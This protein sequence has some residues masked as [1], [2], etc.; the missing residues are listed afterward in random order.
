M[1]V[2]V[3]G[4]D[5][6]RQLAGLL[7]RF[8]ESEQPDG[9]AFATDL[10]RWW[11]AHQASHVAFLAELPSGTSVGMA[12]LAIAAKVPRPGGRGRL[13]GDIQSLYVVPEHRSAG[14]GTALIE[15]VARQADA[16]GLEHV[17]VH[18]NRRARPLYERG[19]FAASRDLLMRAQGKR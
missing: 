11:E 18:A 10:L 17:T 14:I 5:D 1:E 3:A 15:A 8:D 2:R 4:A 7:G 9:P 16:L 6:M 19:G 12:W 13:C